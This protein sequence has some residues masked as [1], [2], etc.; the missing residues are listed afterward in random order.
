MCVCVCLSL[1]LSLSLCLSLWLPFFLT[2]QGSL[3]IFLE[4]MEADWDRIYKTALSRGVLIPENVMRS[5]AVGISG[6]LTYLG[7]NNLL[8][9][10]EQ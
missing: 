4:L 2:P 10:G 3:F 5:V 1:S 7:Q 8:H 9:R 6:A